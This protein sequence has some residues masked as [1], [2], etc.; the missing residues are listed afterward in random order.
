MTIKWKIVE[1]L[2]LG[3]K[4]SYL[5]LSLQNSVYMGPTVTVQWPKIMRNF[6]IFLC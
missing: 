2:E 3:M 1:F 4:P 6:S 5:N